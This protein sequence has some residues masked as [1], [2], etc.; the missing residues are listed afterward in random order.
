MPYETLLVEKTDTTSVV[1]LNRPAK[2]NAINAK[3]MAELAQL[4]TELKEDVNTKFVIFTGAGKAFTGGADIAGRQSGGL[5]YAYVQ[6][7]AQLRGHDLIRNLENLEQITIAA[8]NGFSLGAGLVIAMGCDFRIASTNA[9][10]GIPEANVGIF[11]TWGCTPRLVSLVGPAKA[12]EMIMTC[13]MMDAEEA[14]RVG[15]VNKVVPP[16]Q[17]MEAAHELVGKVGSKAP[18]AVRMAKKIVNA[19]AAPGFGN[20]YLCEPELVER[21]YLSQDPAEGARAFQEKRPPR[22]TGT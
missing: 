10:F 15:L 9:V 12:K 1:T 4:L 11:F 17:L 20:L 5:E 22:F 16:E 7:L 8:V 3:M 14:F 18:L 13:D 2:L 19:A 6:R 21:L